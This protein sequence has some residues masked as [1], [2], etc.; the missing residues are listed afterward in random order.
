MPGQGHFIAIETAD[1]NRVNQLL[2][3]VKRELDDMPIKA[4]QVFLIEIVRLL[5]PEADK[6]KGA[7][8]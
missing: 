2:K 1:R 6:L 4:R 3:F 5:K 7:D 8:T